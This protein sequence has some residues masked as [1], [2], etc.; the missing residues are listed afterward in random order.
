M[1]L[2]IKGF[3]GIIVI[4]D[5][6]VWIFNVFVLMLLMIIFFWGFGMCMNVVISEDF[7]VLL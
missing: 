5:F 6:S 7:L 3:C 1:L 2:K 4:D